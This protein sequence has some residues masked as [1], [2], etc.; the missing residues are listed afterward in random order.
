MSLTCISV[1]I[2]LFSDKIVFI[3]FFSIPEP[4]LC[5]YINASR[6]VIIKP[7]CIQISCIFY[8]NGVV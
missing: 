4:L 2:C 7:V 3:Y 5:N 6:L 8:S 1:H